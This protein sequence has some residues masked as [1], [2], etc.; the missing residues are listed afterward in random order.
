MKTKGDR[1]LRGK[2][3]VIT[4]CLQ[5]IGKE[6]L[7]V[8]AENGSNVF[9][10]SYKYDEE[11][12]SFC[13]DLAEKNDVKVVPVYFD[14]MDDDSIKKAAMAIQKEKMAINGLVNIA[15]MN[16]DAYFGMITSSDM[17]ATFQVNVFAQITFTQYIAKMIKK[18]EDGGSILFTSSI[19]AMD[20]NEGQTVYGASK[21]ALIGAMKTMAIELGKNKI[22]VNAIAPGVIYSPMTQ[23]LSQD[24]MNEKIRRM[25]IPELGSMT[26]VANLCMYLMSDYSSHVTG[27]VIRIDGG[28]N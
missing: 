12:E 3:F 24:I 27:Q 8:F 5:G 22:R 15:G 10:C 17:T 1:L 2:T 14:M 26:D 7:K 19:T 6:T 16:K 18:N 13:N 20:G 28:I 9:A 25:D 23:K 4:G 11:F 21:A